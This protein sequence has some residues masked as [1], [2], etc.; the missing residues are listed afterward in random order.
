MNEWNNAIRTIL[1]CIIILIIGIIISYLLMDQI[2]GDIP[3][4]NA[5]SI[6]I[7][8]CA[9]WSTT[10]TV[11]IFNALQNKCIDSGVIT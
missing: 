1:Y 8:R 10:G 3:Q 11:W 9:N 7:T 2:I 5:T 6:N 4:F